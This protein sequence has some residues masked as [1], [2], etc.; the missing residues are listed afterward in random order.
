VRRGPDGIEARGWGFGRFFIFGVLLR[1]SMIR[2]GFRRNC[3]FSRWS[4]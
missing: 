1:L 2:G 4:Q 3:T